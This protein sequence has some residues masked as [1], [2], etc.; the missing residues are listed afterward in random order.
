M[1]YQPARDSVGELAQVRGLLESA[2]VLVQ[3]DRNKEHFLAASLRS[4]NGPCQGG[5][6]KRK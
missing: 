3:Q 2:L 1:I 5:D 4:V 6:D